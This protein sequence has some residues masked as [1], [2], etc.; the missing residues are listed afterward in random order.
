MDTPLHVLL[1]DDDQDDKLLFQEALGSVRYHTSFNYFSRG[2]DALK[3]LTSATDLPHYIFLDLNMPCMNGKEVLAE[4]KAQHH[5]QHIPVIIYSTSSNEDDKRECQY[6]GAALYLTKPYR[7]SELK[8]S[9]G[10]VLE[11]VS[12]QSL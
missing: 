4:I 10:F 3:W 12:L 8:D 7:L 9:I 6:L 2:A 11:Q 5:L 1:V